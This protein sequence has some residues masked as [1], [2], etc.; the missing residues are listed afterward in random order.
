MVVKNSKS[1][2]AE[3][4]YRLPARS[5]NNIINYNTGIG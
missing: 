3:K 5:G 4:K 1:L 2:K